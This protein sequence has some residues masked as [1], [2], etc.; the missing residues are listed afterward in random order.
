VGDELDWLPRGEKVRVR[1]LQNHDRQVDEIHRGQRAAI[2]LAG[3]RHEEVIR[4]QE[5][6]TPGYLVP[7]RVMTLRL[8]CLAD[9]RR[10]IKHRAPV[11][12]HI[13]TAEVMGTLSLLD[14]DAIEPGGWGL[15]QVF[16]EEPAVAV[17][18][19]PFVIRGPSATQTLGGGQ[20]LQPVARKVRRRHLDILER[21]ERLWSGDARER[22]R[23]AAWFG[24]LAGITLADLVRS[25]SLGPEQAQEIVTRLKEEGELMEV[26]AGTG[27]RLLL[28]ADILKDLDDKILQVLGRFHEN[29]PLVTA[30]DR[31][32]VESQ[33][34]YLAEETLVHAAVTRLLEASR[35]VGDLRR[36]AR[37]DYK[38][39]L[40]VNQRRLKERLIAAYREGGFQ[41]PDPTS[42][43]GQAGGN[44]DHLADIFE[45]CVTEGYLTVI[46]EG[47]YLYADTETE[48]RRRV[49]DKLAEAPRL[50][51]ADIRDLLGTTRKYAVPLCEYLDR[52]GLTR[53]QGDYR[54]LA[55][56]HSPQR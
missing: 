27:R 28:H 47:L 21:V 11:R 12:F 7:A 6:A 37:A 39:K 52:I 55:E 44:A 23:L 50:T 13:G 25:A 22:A 10:P 40:S 35:L 18:G 9:V 48:M 8:H 31:Q 17:W 49:R 43:A 36:I 14:C 4:G 26:V 30:H 45:L 1:S 33:L 32:K 16:L 42:F 15:A 54:T 46:A 24:G 2:N 41:P 19:Q 53:R 5:L 29:Y 38:P 56:D 51:V 20:V 34:D 3:V